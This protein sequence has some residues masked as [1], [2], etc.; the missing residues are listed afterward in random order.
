VSLELA[1]AGVP[2]VIAYRAAAITAAV[3]RRLA[4][5]RFASIVNLVHDRAVVPE[6]MQERCRPQPLAAAVAALVRDPAARRAQV[7][8]CR[9][10]VR[11]LGLG[12]RR[13]SEHAAQ[14]ILDI[15]ARRDD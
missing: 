8:D 3:V 5:V 14:I 7:E 4:R 1:I 10:A 2:M 13:P 6:L 15:I 12:A 9:Q 11:M